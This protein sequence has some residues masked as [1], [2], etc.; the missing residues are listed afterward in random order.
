MQASRPRRKVILI[1]NAYWPSIGGVENSIRH[2]AHEAKS[3]DDDVCIVASD[4]GLTSTQD[5]GVHDPSDV[6][7]YRYQQKPLKFGVLKPLNFLLSVW[8]LL[9]IV[10]KL[11][12]SRPDAVVIARHHFGVI[13]AIL[14]GF[15]DV[16]YLV[17]TVIPFQAQAEIHE[18]QTR[19]A[20]GEF[21]HKLFL[22]L[23]TYTQRYAIRSSRIFLFSETMRRQCEQLVG[24]VLERCI[25]TKPGVDQNRFH[26]VSREETL[27]IRQDL[28]LPLLRPIVLFVGRF[29]K[30]KGGADI[31]AAIA[32]I[33]ECHAV[34]VGAGPEREHYERIMREYSL[35][36]RLSIF[37]SCRDVEKYYQCADLFVMASRYE[38]LGQTIL[39]ALCSGL[40]VVAYRSSSDVSTA[41]GEIG[42]DEFICYAEE[43]TPDSLSRAIRSGLEESRRKDRE[44]I[45]NKAAQRFSWA[46]LY[47]QLSE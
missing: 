24:G 11:Y 21:R 7:L 13:A 32:R 38:M 47:E 39:E 19:G 31:L 16:R 5:P 25:I 27:R 34:F 44:T 37:P 18:E 35:K 29:V 14:S 12:Q 10:R 6:D 45:S 33:P 9:R 8:Q 1:N 28:R 17:P 26:P 4:I 2:L 43:F 40:L 46:N 30:G 20:I 15:E 36:D 42:M 23:H 3:R 22:L 41:T